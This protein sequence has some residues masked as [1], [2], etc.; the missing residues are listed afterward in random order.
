MH[1]YFQ[2]QLC[3]KDCFH[4]YLF[5]DFLA[6]SSRSWGDVRQQEGRRHWYSPSPTAISVE[7]TGY[8]LLSQIKL[9]DIDYAT[10]IANWLSMQQNYGGGFVSTQVN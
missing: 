10:D 1:V 6:S 2:D 9:D 5:S 7:T 8:A 4:I 3:S